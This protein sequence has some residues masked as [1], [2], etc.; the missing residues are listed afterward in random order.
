[1]HVQR[2]FIKG[3]DF[4]DWKQCCIQRVG[5]FDLMLESWAVIDFAKRRSLLPAIDFDLT[6]LNG[7]RDF[8]KSDYH[9][10]AVRQ[11]INR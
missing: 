4:A 1:M 2:E 11:K 8:M 9:S 7:S 5:L 10:N 3:A 6:H